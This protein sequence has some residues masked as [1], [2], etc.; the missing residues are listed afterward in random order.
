ML[1]TVVLL[2]IFCGNW[3]LF[4]GLFDKYAKKFEIKAFILDI[5]Y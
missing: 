3:L 4:S 2:K 1:K 5:I